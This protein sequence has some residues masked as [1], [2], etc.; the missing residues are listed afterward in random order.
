MLEKE[1]QL[2]IT[3]FKILLAKTED[4][5]EFWINEKRSIL[6]YVN[7]FRQEANWLNQF[8]CDKLFLNSKTVLKYF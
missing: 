7:R 8:L 2:R 4:S 1:S 5:V 3:N 6:I